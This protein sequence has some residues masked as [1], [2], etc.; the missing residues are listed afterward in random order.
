MRSNIKSTLRAQKQTITFLTSAAEEAIVAHAK[1]NNNKKQQN[2][3][4]DDVS[5][6]NQQTFLFI[7]V[8][9]I[10]MENKTFK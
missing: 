1:N 8:L 2:K 5:M 4:L 3:S 6:G 10:E 7:L 9:S